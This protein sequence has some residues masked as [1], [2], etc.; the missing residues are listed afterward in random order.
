VSFDAAL[1]YARRHELHALAVVQNG[2]VVLEE[3]AGGCTADQAHPLYSGAKSFW[4]VTAVAA[5][6]DGLFQLD[7]PVAQTI[8]SWQDGALRSQVTLRHLL[9]LTSGIRFGGLGRA[10]PTFDK[11]VSSDITAVPGT[12][13]TYGG[14]P[15]QVFGAVLQRKLVGRGLSPHA[16]LQER[17]LNPIGMC[18]TRWRTLPDGNSP[19][20]TG[21]FVTAREWL[22]FG[23]FVLQKGLWNNKPVVRGRSLATCFEGSSANPKYGLGFWLRPVESPSDIVYASGSGGQALYI[24]PSLKTMVVHFGNSASYRHAVFLK[25]LL[26]DLGPG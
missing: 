12:K 19:L 25:K 18:I 22:K 11:S 2:T 5:Q 14:I 8:E 15:L 1:E 6:D 24:I 10:V 7:E 13:F 23:Q 21:A 4:G 17:I 26:Q 20:P 9:Q 3:Y 16:Y